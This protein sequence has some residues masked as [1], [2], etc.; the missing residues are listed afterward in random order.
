L[1][2]LVMVQHSPSQILD[3]IVSVAMM[4]REDRALVKVIAGGNGVI[5]RG[6]GTL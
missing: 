2:L 3:G 6:Q 4:K 1:R 5:G